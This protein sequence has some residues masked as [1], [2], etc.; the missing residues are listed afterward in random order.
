MSRSHLTAEVPTVAGQSKSGR[1]SPTRI[2][3]GVLGNWS[4]LALNV[5]VAFWMTPFVVRHL[6]DAS[7]GLWA[8][9]LQLTGY[10]GVIDVGL[11]S[12]LVRFVSRF[13]ARGDDEGLNRLMNSTFTLYLLMVP[14]CL[15]M[16]SMV[17]FIA[18]PHMHIPSAMLGVAQITVFIAAGCIACDFLFATS[19]A[20]LAGLS[21]WDLINSVWISVLLART[22][23]IV[24]FL[25]SGFGLLALA[26]IQ[27]SVTFIGYSAEMFLLRRVLPTF[28]PTWHFPKFDEMRPIAQHGWY[29]FL[30]SVA[31]KINYQ[32][33]SIVIALFLPIDQVTFYVIGLR[34][35]EHLRELLTSTTMVI[36]PVISSFEAVGELHRITTALIRSTKYSL[37]VGLLGASV[38][39]ALGTDFIRLWMG[40]R[41]SGPS[42]NVLVILSVGVVLS[43]TQFASS[44]VLYGL[45]KHRLNV[46]WTIIESVLNVGFSLALVRRYGILGVAAGTTIANGLV[47]AWLFPRSFLKALEVPWKL[48]VQDAI[49]PALGPALSFVAGAMLYKNFFPIQSFGELVL[50]LASGLFPFLACLWFVGLDERDRKSVRQKTGQLGLSALAP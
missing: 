12:A 25:K 15:A 45:S 35:V 49:I 36:A 5:L 3:K 1:I 14:V 16:A 17:A 41:F 26:W 7:Y 24:L 9:V 48:Y 39:L 42:G 6:G 23:L 11:R 22:L 43:C 13:N 37:F 40:P 33:D 4:Y 31:T 47:R 29:S 38:L 34:L 21:R 20:S 44:H 46:N 10:M 19:H 27:L 18:L 2:A 28:R 50:A 32:I 8:L 30:L